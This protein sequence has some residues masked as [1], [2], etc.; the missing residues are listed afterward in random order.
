MRLSHQPYVKLDESEVYIRS[1]A[2]RMDLFI[3]ATL[4]TPTK[5]TVLF[6]GLQPLQSEPTATTVSVRKMATTSRLLSG[7]L[8]LAIRHLPR[9][10]GPFLTSVY[11]TLSIIHTFL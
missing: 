7:I 5:I 10:S 8:L 4:I 1:S 3:L 2:N 9:T 6:V 11:A